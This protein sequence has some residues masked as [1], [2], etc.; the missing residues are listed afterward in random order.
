MR[1][2]VYRLLRQ[3]WEQFAAHGFKTVILRRVPKDGGGTQEQTVD[4]VSWYCAHE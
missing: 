1:V 3:V 4:E 2:L